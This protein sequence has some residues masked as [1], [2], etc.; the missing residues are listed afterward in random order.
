MFQNSGKV[1]VASSVTLM[2]VAA[3]EGVGGLLLEPRLELDR[4]LKVAP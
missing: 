1:S 2:A 3:D 4:A